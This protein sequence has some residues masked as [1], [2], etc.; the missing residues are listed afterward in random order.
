MSLIGCEKNTSQKEVEENI[1][2]EMNPSFS[3]IS[4]STTYDFKVTLKSKMPLGGVII[5]IIAIDEG[6]GTP[7]LPQAL[8]ITSITSVSNLSVL[9]LPRQKWV[10]TTVKVTSKQTATNSATAKFRVIYK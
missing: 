7:I 10:E 1:N 4:S 5:D 6:S 9:N 8:G 2:F 3:S